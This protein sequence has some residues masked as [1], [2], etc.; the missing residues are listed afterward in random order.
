MICAHSGIQVAQKNNS[1]EAYTLIS[2]TGP[3]VEL[4]QRVRRH[5]DSPLPGSTILSKL[6]LTVNHTPRSLDS[7][8]RFPYQKNM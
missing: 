6:F 5:S 2:V 7:L 1:V 4:R 8:E 3:V